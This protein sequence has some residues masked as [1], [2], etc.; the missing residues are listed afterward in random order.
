VGGSIGRSPS[1][2]KG[3]GL[4]PLQVSSR[5]NLADLAN[6]SL[7]KVRTLID[8][9]HAWTVCATTMDSLDCGL[10]GLSVGS[11][12]RLVSWLNRLPASSPTMTTSHSRILARGSWPCS[13]RLSPRTSV[14]LSPHRTSAALSPPGVQSRTCSALALQ[15]R[16]RPSVELDVSY[17]I[18]FQFEEMIY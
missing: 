5:V 6:K 7:K 18:R 11:S 2:Y 9:A 12:A 16:G 4:D 17:S 8:S 3:G 13:L 15:C 10:F 14:A 1:S